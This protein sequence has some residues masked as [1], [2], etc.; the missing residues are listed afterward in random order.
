MVG[1]ETPT[2]DE[3]EIA[4]GMML[5]GNGIVFGELGGG[6]GMGE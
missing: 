3:D 1:D 5:G 4:R 2:L 6:V